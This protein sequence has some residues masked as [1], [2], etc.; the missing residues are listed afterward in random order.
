MRTNSA[1]L[2]MVL[3]V[4]SGLA[5][6][7]TDPARTQQ[8]EAVKSDKVKTRSEKDNVVRIS[9]TLVQVD[10]V[11]TDRQGKQVTDLQPSDFE[12]SED[13]RPQ[14]ITNFSYISTQPDSPAPPKTE[15]GS[16]GPLPIGPPTRLR[17]DQV[18]RTVALVVD[19]LGLS[20]E[21]TV[22]VRDALKR[23]V[24]QQM[25]PGDL[26]AILRTGAGMGALQQFTADKRQLYAAIERVRWNMIGRGA[27]GAFAPIDTHP[28]GGVVGEKVDELRTEIYSVGTLGAL[29]F[30]IRG[31]RALPGRKSVIL[32][33]DGFKLFSGDLSGQGRYQGSQR[34]LDALRKLTDLANRASV[35]VY[36]IDA[37]G[38]QT[39]APSAA[40]IIGLQSTDIRSALELPR[41]DRPERQERFDTK[42]E[43]RFQELSDTQQG[44]Q[45][46][47]QETGGLAIYNTN[48]LARGVNRIL[49]DQRGYYLLGYIPEQT[50]FRLENGRRKFHR[51][52]LKVKRAGLHV[53]SRSGFYGIADE[54]ARPAPRTAYQQVF[55]AL[56]SP[57]AAGD[58]S[59]KLTS[60]FGHEAKAGSI[61]RSLLHI[62]PRNLTFSKQPDGSYQSVM[63]IAAV[64][65]SDNGQ[66]VQQ[67]ARTYTLH[68]PA[69][70]FERM[71][72]RGFLYTINLPVKKPGA[73]QLRV[74][75]RDSESERVG[76]ANQFIE[77]PDLDKRRLTL[78]GLVVSG[79]NLA[80]QSSAEQADGQ[81]AQQAASE[82]EGAVQD[83]DPLAG[84]AVRILQSGMELDYGFLIYNAL[85][86]P[87][88]KRPQLEAQVLLLKDGKQ[89]FAGRLNP[90]TVSGQHD[91]K[92]I[93]AVGRIRLGPE[94]TPGEYVLQVMV[95]DKLAK[96][97]YR[98]ATQW[99]DFELTK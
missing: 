17:P 69:S 18:R 54:E 87:K 81:A 52:T 49:D 9:V 20:F 91:L 45:Y 42:Q 47:A 40:D 8:R 82:K 22:V 68:V 60:L 70:Q 85:L 39:L 55:A 46:L 76:S 96:E 23:F 64:T 75:V 33:S 97:K 11:V 84:P 99:M 59:L 43:S 61:V 74:A 13:G 29:N 73:Y 93:R 38:L 30:V 19:D 63:D 1:L 37:R 58:V 2:C 5:F 50:T 14:H 71:M 57:F 31:L 7:Q 44:L 88:T 41:L 27:I 28:S 98:T 62:E 53:R 25:E 90:L 12:I 34:V 51:I 66:I 79:I 3:T 4:V 89:I 32:F 94:L 26:V 56:M 35:V 72:Q 83:F 16:R 95:T 36:T 15:S 21:S 10:A 80:K 67:E 86:D 48:D 65:F 77:V 78:S 24:D 6:S 92:H